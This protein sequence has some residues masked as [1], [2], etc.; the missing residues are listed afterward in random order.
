MRADLNCKC[1]APGT[2]GFIFLPKD[3]AQDAPT[4][5]LC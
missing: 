1:H 3:A 5:S 2:D 4:Y